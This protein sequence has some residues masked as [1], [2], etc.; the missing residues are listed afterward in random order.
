MAERCARRRIAVIAL[1]ASTCL[2]AICLAATSAILAQVRESEGSDIQGCPERVITIKRVWRDASQCDADGVAYE[3]F[4]RGQLSHAQDLAAM[5]R[6]TPYELSVSSSFLNGVERALPSD[7]RRCA[8]DGGLCMHTNLS[9]WHVPLEKVATSCESQLRVGPWH[10]GARVPPLKGAPASPITCAVVG[11]GGV[12]SGRECG[13][14]IDE[15][16]MIFRAN[17]PPIRGYEA[18]VGSRTDVHVLNVFWSDWLA[19]HAKLREYSDVADVPK[20]FLDPNASLS[21]IFSSD[22]D[23]G[24][25]AADASRWSC[26]RAGSWAFAFHAKAWRVYRMTTPLL[27][28]LRRWY[29][30]VADKGKPTTGML[31]FFS[32]AAQCDEVRLYGFR[33]FG[34][35]Q[36]Y[37]SH[38]QR[39]RMAESQSPP[40]H[41]RVSTAEESRAQPP[42][43]LEKGFRADKVWW[44]D[45]NTEHSLF[46]LFEASGLQ[47][48][49]CGSDGNP[50]PPPPP[51]APSPSPKR[52]HETGP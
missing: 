13:A 2:A 39:R 31:A 26:R 4:S 41:E 1:V 20:G 29:D 36:H 11:S 32:A 21:F 22:A 27:L 47:L 43:G 18:D 33:D 25:D 15:A 28:T 14:R 52:H 3:G 17:N 42:A 19:G 44:H 46:D 40:M 5:G 24:D 34:G 51:A 37:Y 10:M 49:I 12:L 16:T 7:A 38:H 48:N 45:F 30:V 23:G 6:A 35:D 9:E 50:P 8:R